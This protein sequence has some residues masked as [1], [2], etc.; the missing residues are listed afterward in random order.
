MATENRRKSRRAAAK[1]IA[2]HLKTDKGLAPCVVEN[3][4]AGG[5]FIRTAR[6]IAVGTE[7]SLSLV[8]AGMRKP[9]SITGRIV[10]SVPAKPSGGRVSPPG[11]SIAFDPLRGEASEPLGRLLRDLGLDT[12]EAPT[13]VSL[14]AQQVEEL[15]EPG[16]E[17]AKLQVQIRGVMMELSDAHDQLDSK[18]REIAHLK[19]E[20][21]KLRA[22]LRDRDGR[23]QKTKATD[24]GR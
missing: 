1:G 13:Q 21:E 2:A 5:I 24:H 12:S 15:A 17:V 8:R 22:Q 7:V 6:L 9:L 14:P 20:V 16:S 4:S 19:A 23:T 18:E 11:M 10:S 3:I